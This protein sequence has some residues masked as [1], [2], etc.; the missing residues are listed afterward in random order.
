MVA[1]VAAVVAA[2]SGGAGAPGDRDTGSDAVEQD[3]A[4]TPSHRAG[5][6][7]T[8]SFDTLIPKPSEVTRSRGAFVLSGEVG[9]GVEGDA[10]AGDAA[11]LLRRRL[12]DAGVTTGAPGD[13][14]AG[15]AGGGD[16]G[17]RGARP[18]IVLTSKGAGA[19]LGAE[20]YRLVIATDGVEVR[21]RGHDGF[22]WGVQTLA[23]LLPASHDDVP[24]AG[25]PGLPA[26]EVRDVPRYRWRGVMLDVA[27]HFFGVD[28]IERVTEL[29]SAYKLNR[30]HLHL[31]D[32]QGWRLAIA[33]H[34]ELAEVG[35]RTEVGGGPGGYL[36]RDQY[37]AVVEHA[38]RLGVTVVPEID[39]PG[40]TNAAL[41][42]LPYLG[43]D[44]RAP[45]PYTGMSVGFSSLCVDAETTYAF[46]TDVIGELAR[47]TPGRWIHIGGDESQ[48]TA[49]DAYRRF[50]AR[51]LAIVRAAGKVPV[52]WEE[53]GDADLSG[54]P[55]IAQHWID[56]A[57]AARAAARGA[58]LVVSPA[59]RV[60]LDMKYDATTPGNA[61]AGL[62]DTR[63]AYSWDPATAVPAARPSQ[64]LGVEAPLWTELVTT[65]ADID[66]RLLPR[67][68]A[69]AEVAWTG[70][71]ARH[72]PD[73]R[74]R[75]AGHAARWAAGGYGYT[76]DP[77]VPWP[78]AR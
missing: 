30:L 31:T 3:G 12:A 42:S 71:G 13:R 25:A 49:P 57:P 63:T 61:W 51:A 36:T 52:G 46:V 65:T 8:G 69:V 32:D 24:G 40:H 28:D 15:P 18:S 43:C 62:I 76:R 27:R 73:F 56:P 20:G 60:Y 1:L 47:L 64:V 23:Q 78:A 17:G 37:R 7:R 6:V 44:G 29:A 39:M 34:P 55:V 11:A 66:A 19:E 59:N 26:G 33:A 54:G 35:G 67:L 53:I 77:G 38:R 72:W 9:V 5:P 70:Q 50:V 22:V 4:S 14:D 48:A 21:A 74:V 16:E 45:A 41:V 10:P 2:C 68:P 75:V 58:E